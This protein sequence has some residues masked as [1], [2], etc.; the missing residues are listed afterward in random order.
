MRASE[1]CISKNVMS[2]LMNQM[3][4]VPVEDKIF[5]PAELLSHEIPFKANFCVFRSERM[6]VEI[7]GF[8]RLTP[9]SAVLVFIFASV[10]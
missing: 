6:A 8:T 9:D 7:R 3:K 1:K 5:Q 4:S 2:H 10:S